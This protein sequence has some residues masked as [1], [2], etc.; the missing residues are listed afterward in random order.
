VRDD[1]ASLEGVDV[2]KLA[3]HT[4]SLKAIAILFGCACEVLKGI[5]EERTYLQGVLRIPQTL[6][7]LLLLDRLGHFWVIGHRPSFNAYLLWVAVCIVGLNVRIPLS[8]SLCYRL[9]ELAL[10]WC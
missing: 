10:L 7:R 2:R 8:R 3:E 9:D 1:G 5:H 6:D 4:Q